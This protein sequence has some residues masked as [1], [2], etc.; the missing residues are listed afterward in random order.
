MNK[1]VVCSMG[2]LI[3]E[4]RGGSKPSSFSDISPHVV[5]YN[6][7]L[8]LAKEIVELWTIPDL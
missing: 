1:W 8:V 6:S 3:S 2:P 5:L 4:R 7:S